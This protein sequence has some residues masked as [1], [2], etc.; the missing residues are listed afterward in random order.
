[1]KP[2]T[3]EYMYMISFIQISKPVNT[4]LW[5]HKSGYWLL[6]VGSWWLGGGKNGTFW[7]SSIFWFGCCCMVSSHG[8]KKKCIEFMICI[9]SQLIS[10]ENQ[11]LMKFTCT[12]FKESNSSTRFKSSISLLPIPLPSLCN[13]HL[14]TDNLSTFFSWFFCF[15]P[16]SHYIT[17][18]IAFLNLSVW[19]IIYWLLNMK[20][21]VVLFLSYISCICLYILSYMYIVFPSSITSQ[22]GLFVILAWLIFNVYMI[23]SI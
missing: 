9:S 21:G 3:K 18:L 6:L 1:M 16:L 23:F 11:K 20:D 13:V 2:E 10:Q 22:H 7:K 15:W 14:P 19:S 8:K 4:D 12:S 5:C 17:C